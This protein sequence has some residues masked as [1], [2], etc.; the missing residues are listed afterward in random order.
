MKDGWFILT[1]S[2]KTNA[3]AAAV[4]FRLYFIQLVFI[5]CFRSINLNG[6]EERI[7]GGWLGETR[8]PMVD[9]IN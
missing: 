8:M 5:F 2:N 9:T 4:T 6:R 1:S 3:A 7:C